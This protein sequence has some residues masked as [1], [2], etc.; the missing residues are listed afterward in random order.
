MNKKIMTAAAVTAAAVSMSAAYA[1]DITVTIDGQNVAFDQPPII[2]NDRTLV[3]MRAIFEALGATVEW[4]GETRTV[5]SVKGETT[6]K[7]TIDSPDMY[8]GEKLVTLDVP[9]K[10][11]SDR[12]LVPVRAISEAM[13]CNVEW[14]GANQQVIITTAATSTEA[15]EATTDPAATAVPEATT[16]PTATAAP[17]ATTAPSSGTTTADDAEE[18]APK[19]GVNTFAHSLVVGVIDPATGEVDASV[20]EKSTTNFVPVNGGKQYFAAVYH[21]NALQYSNV[22]KGYAF[23]DKD[24]KYISGDAGD[25]STLVT[26]PENAAYIRYSIEFPTVSRNTLYVNFMET[27][28]APTE[29]T[30]SESITKKAVTD[31]LADKSVYMLADGSVTSSDPWLTMLDEAINAKQLYIKAEDGLRYTGKTG[32]ALAAQS[33]IAQLPKSGYD[34]L[35]V[36]AGSYDWMQN[37]DI[38]DFEKAVTTFVQGAKK[39]V[40]GADIYLATIPTGKNASFKDGIT[41]EGGSSNADYTAVI[42]KVAE[43]EKVNVIDIAALWGSDEIETYLRSTD[44]NQYLFANE[45]GSEKITDAIVKALTE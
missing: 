26:A 30:K 5:T 17:E 23:Y 33:Y 24:K 39:Q 28:K 18:I 45:A 2:D 38:A 37:M 14:D 34:A 42:K 43:A 20:T 36:Y 44:G 7:L 16:D 4:D 11:V 19:E 40:S 25:L 32:V 3:P 6:I 31:K 15:P 29:F 27:S 22:C 10:I 1:Q 9:A 13:D 35:I 8:V 21:P 41:N 12:T